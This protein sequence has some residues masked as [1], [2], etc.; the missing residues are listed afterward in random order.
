MSGRTNTIA[1]WNSHWLAY[2]DSAKLNPAQDY[3]RQRII[4]ELAIPGDQTVVDIGSGQGDMAADLRTAFPWATILGLELSASGVQI[5]QRKVPT[6]FFIQ[7]DLMLAQTPEPKWKSAADFAVCSEVLEHLTDPEVFLRNIQAY[8]KPGAKLVVTVPGGPMSYF[9]RHIGHQGHFTAERLA[10]VL[11]AAGFTDVR[12]DRAG[13][14]FFNLYRLVV[15][16]RGA[17]LVQDASRD[18]RG[19]G[20]WLSRAVMRVFALLF[21]LNLPRSPWGWQ[22][23]ARATAPK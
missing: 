8:L 16:A 3:R 13:F 22:M 19:F 14:P 9:D 23:V 6:A 5:A 7:A 18:S 17:A 15:I 10:K 20:A 4:A 11:S 1:D 12:V 21:R 2:A